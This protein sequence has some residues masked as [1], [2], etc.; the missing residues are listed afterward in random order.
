MVKVSFK[1][2]AMQYWWLF[3]AAIV[4]PIIGIVGYFLAFCGALH[5]KSIWA[6]I[7]MGCISYIG[8]VAWGIFI[9][10]DGWLRQKEQEY[11]DFPRI[12]LYCIS[13]S[14]DQTVFE[15]DD[16]DGIQLEE[17]I[18]ADQF[19][20]MKYR[21]E[22]IGSHT[23]FNFHSIFIA[24]FFNGP[25]YIKQHSDFFH[26]T[27]A[28]IASFRESMDLY[29]G[30]LKQFV[31]NDPKTINH[32]IGYLF[33]FQ[34]DMMKR[35]YCSCEVNIT[36]GKNRFLNKV[37]IFTDKEYNEIISKYQKVYGK[38]QYPYSEIFGI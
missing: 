4:I 9:Y 2:F 20:F 19:F 12:K 10:Y 24:V 34:D 37:R 15:F 11:R 17:K 18:F 22:N 8:T 26:M 25:G 29:A 13:K 32:S 38:D 3:L 35:Y 1:Y 33:S 36:D 27:M 21:L 23:L 16:I 28:N 14:K 6:T 31:G 5:D 7:V 30:V